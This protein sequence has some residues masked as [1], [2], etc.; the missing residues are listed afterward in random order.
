[1]LHL[2]LFCMFRIPAW[3]LPPSVNNCR[4]GNSNIMNFPEGSGSYVIADNIIECLSL[5]HNSGLTV[6]YKNNCG[7]LEPVVI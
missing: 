2:L 5:D 1:M 3:E 6:L 7:L 4:P